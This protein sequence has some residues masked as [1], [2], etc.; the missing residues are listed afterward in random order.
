MVALVF[1]QLVRTSDRPIILTNTDISVSVSVRKIIKYY[2][3]IVIGIGIGIG[4]GK[5]Y[6]SLC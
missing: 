3:G 2:I 5:K 1:W 4:I 6:Q